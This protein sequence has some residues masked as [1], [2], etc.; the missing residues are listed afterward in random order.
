MKMKNLHTRACIFSR[1][2]V[3]LFR[4]KEL[5]NAASLQCGVNYHV[6]IFKRVTS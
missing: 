5:I 6:S 3:M 2:L 1:V 4:L